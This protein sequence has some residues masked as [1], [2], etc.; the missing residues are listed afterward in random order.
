MYTYECIVYIV[1]VGLECFCSFLGM[2]CVE[3]VWLIAGLERTRTR[4]PLF[5]IIHS[6]MTFKEQL[7]KSAQYK[8]LYSINIKYTIKKPTNG[9]TWPESDGLDSGW[10]GL[11]TCG[12]AQ[13]WHPG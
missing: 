12:A 1:Y 8:R 10:V 13:S 6:T 11:Q 5:V 9:L 2:M 7:L 3:C 4:K